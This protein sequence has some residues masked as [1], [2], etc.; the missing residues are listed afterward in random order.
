[1]GGGF[2]GAVF[3]LKAL[4][5]LPDADIVLIERRRALGRGLAYGACAPFHLLNVPVSRAEIGLEPGFADWLKDQSFDLTAALA[6]SGGDLTS[7]FVVR[8]AFG[9]YLEALTRKAAAGR[10]RLKVVHA[11]AVRLE[12]S[13]TPAVVLDDGRTVKADSIVLATGNLPASPL[14]IPGLMSDVS[15]ANDPWA[16]DALDGIDPSAPVLLVGTGL[17]MVDVVLKLVEGGHRGPLLALS[18]HGVVPATHAAGGFWAPFMDAGHV[19]PLQALRSVRAAIAQAEAQA[20]PWQRVID[21]VRP[22]TARIWHGWSG[23][24]RLQ[25]FRHLRTLWTSVRHRMAPRVASRLRDL[26]ASGQLRIA[27]GRIRRAEPF[28]DGI[29]VAFG[30][31]GAGQE[32]FRAAR[33]FNCTGPRG[34]V[35]AIAHP[36]L[37]DLVRKHLVLP[38]ALGLGIETDDSAV[39]DSRGNISRW[40]FALGPLTRPAWWEITAIPE[41]NTQIER[42]VQKLAVTQAGRPPQWSLLADE[43]VDLGAGI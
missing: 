19:S 13:P 1:M 14:A 40:L 33:M 28:P 17:T 36:L 39:L 22:A 16:A 4:R 5:G 11:E 26:T 29:D 37:A 38:D 12:D 18:R 43:F 27:A 6:E 21:A 3:A 23:A 24:E 9:A 30:T 15:V 2:S 7:A 31:P 32:H 42:L 41:I 34:D 8:D 20:V 35:S 25:F 10:S